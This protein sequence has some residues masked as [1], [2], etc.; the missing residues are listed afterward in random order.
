MD[1]LW[2][3]VHPRDRAQVQEAEQKKR[4]AEDA[5]RRLNHEVDELFRR[6]RKQD[7]RRQSRL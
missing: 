4:Q 2:E 6:E 3:L 1:F 5:Y 7:E